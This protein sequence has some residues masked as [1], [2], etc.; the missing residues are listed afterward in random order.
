MA[1]QLE[2]EDLPIDA[3][4]VMTLILS[5]SV[6]SNILARAKME[7]ARNRLTLSPSMNL[8]M[9]GYEASCPVPDIL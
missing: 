1:L 4:W 9:D 5:I 8:G 7:I 2:G 3:P 6:T